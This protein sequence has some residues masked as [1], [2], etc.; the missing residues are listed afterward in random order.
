MAQKDRQRHL[1]HPVAS[2]SQTQVMAFA[3]G[4]DATYDTNDLIEADM[5][6]DLPP[7]LIKTGLLDFIHDP[8]ICLTQQLQALRSDPTD[9]ADG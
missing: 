8:I 9:H 7:V 2:M 4:V 1:R 5:A 3:A 6:K